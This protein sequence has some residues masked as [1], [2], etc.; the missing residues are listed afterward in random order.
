MSRRIRATAVV[1][2][3]FSLAGCGGGGDSSTPARTTATVPAEDGPL[4]KTEY[5]REMRSA[6][7]RARRAI[8]EAEKSGRGERERAR[9]AATSLSELDGR[10]RE[11]EPPA[12]VVRAHDDYR[13]GVEAIGDALAATYAENRGGDPAF[14]K[15]LDEL[16][17]PS[18]RVV[19]RARAARATFERLGYDL[20]EDGLAD[21]SP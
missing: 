7:D 18:P 8:E 12:E 20:G 21:V 1:S 11:L 5:E 13:A 14:Q 4:T 17:T 3:A 15:K 10:M 6:I 2:I 16:K 9:V 19:K